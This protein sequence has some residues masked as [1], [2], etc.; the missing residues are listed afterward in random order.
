VPGSFVQDG[1]STIWA[2]PRPSGPAS[3]SATVASG[4]AAARRDATTHPADPPPTIT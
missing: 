2:T 4:D 3:I 1:G